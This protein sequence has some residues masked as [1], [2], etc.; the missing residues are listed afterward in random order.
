MSIPEFSFKHQTLPSSRAAVLGDIT[1]SRESVVIDFSSTFTNNQE[2]AIS[3]NGYPVSGNEINISGIIGNLVVTDK[4]LDNGTFLFYEYQPKYDVATSGVL[5]TDSNGDVVQHRVQFA[6]VAPTGAGPLG[7]FLLKDHSEVDYDVLAGHSEIGI[8]A[9]SV[10]F[11]PVSSPSGNLGYKTY[12]DSFALGLLRFPE[13][14]GSSLPS[15]GLVDFTFLSES[16]SAYQPMIYADDW[17]VSVGSGQVGLTVNGSSTSVIPI[18]NGAWYRGRL[19]YNKSGTTELD[20][21]QENLI[22]SRVVASTI[23]PSGFSLSS[24]AL[25][26][27]HL[28]VYRYIPT[29]DW[30]LPVVCPRYDHAIT[31]QDSPVDLAPPYRMRILTG[32]DSQSF[33]TYDAWMKDGT[34]NQNQVEPMNLVPIYKESV[35]E[36][37][38]WTRFQNVMSLT[39]PLANASTVYIMPVREGLVSVSVVDNEIVVTNGSFKSDPFDLLNGKYT[40]QIS[41]FQDLM[42]FEVDNQNIIVPHSLKEVRNKAKV[43]SAYS[44]QV[45]PMNVFEGRYPLYQ[46][47]LTEDI[48]KTVVNDSVTSVQGTI[49][50]VTWRKTRGICV[51]VNGSRIS[52]SAIRNFDMN[53]GIIYV[54]T[55]LRPEDNV[56]VTYLRTADYFICNFPRIRPELVTDNSWRVYLRSLWP[57]YFLENPSDTIERLAYKVLVNGTPTGDLRS[58]VSNQIVTEYEGMIRLADVS[59]APMVTFQDARTFGGGLLSDS[60]FGGVQ[61]RKSAYRHSI[62]FTD[63]ARFQSSTPLNVANILPWPTLIVKIPLSVK[64]EMEGRFESSDTALEYIKQTIEKHLALGTYYVI[65]DENNELWDKPFPSVGPK[66]LRQ[67]IMERL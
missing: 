66:V 60:H 3:V 9:G 59:L 15:S 37:N 31:W 34:I 55:P 56:E 30:D 20:V 58:C 16:T 42:P 5:V 48:I 67:A 13:F 8:P 6:S 61:G 4:I 7:S 19:L 1:V 14:N 10:T 43:L 62:Y 39:G 21:Y 32:S 38:D 64:A 57:N 27:N 54:N 17:K 47:E 33:L 45:L 53:N 50:N 63:I 44:A 18:S 23:T 2:A 40:Y 49:Q 36:T 12:S 29:F 26:V 24:D 22:D 35:T 25:G 51:Y 28:A 46:P 41:E 52:Q 65:V 11:S